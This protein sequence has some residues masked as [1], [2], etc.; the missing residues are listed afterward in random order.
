MIIK[1]R[2]FTLFARRPKITG[3]SVPSSTTITEIGG[4]YKINPTF[5]PS[6]VIDTDVIYASSNIASVSVDSD[7]IVTALRQGS[8][9]ITVM[10]KSNASVKATMIVTVLPETDKITLSNTYYIFE[11][12]GDTKQ[13]TAS[14]SPS[15]AN[16]SLTWTSS[17]TAIATVDNNGL[18][19]AK[20][21]G[22][23]YITAKAGNASTNCSIK[24]RQNATGISLSYTN[25]DININSTAKIDAIVTPS[26][27]TDKLVFWR[28]SDMNIASVDND[29]VITG[30]GS[31]TCVITAVANSNNLLVAS[32]TV[33][34]HILADGVSLSQDS[35]SFGNIYENKQL[36]AN[37]FPHNATDKTVTW[38]SSNTNVAK[39]DDNGNV[40]S[41]G[42]GT[43]TITATNAQGYASNASVT[44]NID[45]ENVYVDKSNITLT[46]IGQTSTVTA[47]VVPSNTGVTPTWTSS[48]T[49]VA[50]V[51]NG[52]IKA[53]KDG[54]ALI[55]VTAGEKRARVFVSVETTAP[56]ITL[57][58]TSHTTTTIG[59]T[60]TLVPT[61][62]PNTSITSFSYSSTNTNV[63]T[64]SSNGLVTIK[65]VG[66]CQIK[67][68]AKGVTAT[69]N[70]TVNPVNVTG[71]TL[72]ATSCS[73]SQLNQTFQIN[74][75]IAPSNATYKT[76]SYNVVTSNAGFTVS[77]TGLVTCTGILGGTIEVVAHNGVKATFK[78]NIS[79]MNIAVGDYSERLASLRQAMQKANEKIA[80]AKVNTAETNLQTQITNLKNN[81]DKELGELESAFTDIRDNVL[82]GLEDGIL[83]EVEKA[84]IQASLDGL[85]SEKADVD[86]Q[87]T[88][89]Y[90][91][92][93]LVDTTSYK[94]KTNLRSSYDTYI[95]RYNNLISNIENLLSINDKINQ[96]H[97]NQY[98]N[99]LD[100]CINAYKNFK[101]YATQAIDAIA[102]RKSDLLYNNSVSYTDAKIKVESDRIT[103]T[104]TSVTQVN[105]KITTL[106][107]TIEALAGQIN[108]KVE[109]NGVSSIIQQNPES[110]RIAFNGIS[111]GMTVTKSGLQLKTDGLVHTVLQNGRL[112]V[113]K[114]DET[115]RLGFIGRSIWS[116]SNTQGMFINMETGCTFALGINHAMGFIYSANTVT[117]GSSGVTVT[118]GTNILGTLNMH[119]SAIKN[120]GAMYTSQ[121]TIGSNYVEAPIIKATSQVKAETIH[122][123]D[124]C[125][126][127]KFITYTSATIQAKNGESRNVS[128]EKTVVDTF[129]ANTEYIGTANVEDGIAIVEL[130]PTLVALGASYVLQITPIGENKKV[131]VLS[132]DRESFTI[133]GDDCEFDYIVKVI[134]PKTPNRLRNMSSND[135]KA[136]A[137]Q[138]Y[139]SIRTDGVFVENIE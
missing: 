118:P 137:Q 12:V 133:K 9:V 106:N 59:Q 64:V 61:L 15:L 1:S 110:V 136:N 95:T 104:V 2:P 33:N 24:V 78:V 60:F 127:K 113:M 81:V 115:S 139:S 6:N 46:S 10:S 86:A 96:T 93:Y 100:N 38:R 98:T 111:S 84:R 27:A 26:N 135:E 14:L 97:I 80:Q 3:I 119:N 37:V 50:T 122:V 74:T 42:R 65:G 138:A 13:I 16:K 52:V 20:S 82:D 125:Q 117:V 67:V 29:G 99:Q 56:T 55:T 44:V 39:V 48:D 75:T 129:T 68:S 85:K 128:V 31:G 34:V 108:S 5:S 71:V 69:C 36:I 109:A 105:N 58:K 88:E 41:I 91:N 66:T 57:N 63:A 62:T 7:G 4:T 79:G 87:Y 19:T 70:I 8:S 45:V 28:S 134:L 126:A 77:N 47:T 123:Y 40:T 17:N 32:A 90:N 76:V 112:E 83:T 114:K 54:T 116:E 73:F 18:I 132:K 51:T 131:Y 120:V 23:C 21:V 121:A 53:I 94:P 72:N 25:L 30:V 92:T 124:W 89:L 107:T 130:P 102:Q 43:C 49:S 35:L 101:K 22:D 103:S 11:S